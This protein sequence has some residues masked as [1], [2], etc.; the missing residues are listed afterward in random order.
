MQGLI[1]GASL[2]LTLTPALE[3]QAGMAGQAGTMP[4]LG[5]P[6]F[7]SFGQGSPGWLWGLTQRPWAP[8]KRRPG[9]WD[10]SGWPGGSSRMSR[11]HSRPTPIPSEALLLPGGDLAPCVEPE[12]LDAEEDAEGS[13]PVSLLPP[14]T[15]EQHGNLTFNH[16]STHLVWNSWLQGRTRS[17]CR[18]SKSL[19]QTTHLGGGTERHPHTDSR[20]DSWRGAKPHPGD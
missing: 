4:S 7:Q 11:L 13:P 20:A 9:K 2:G 12:L 14:H 19:K 16:L 5:P 8:R 3:T 18:A 15:W 10:T 1:A 6:S 17:S